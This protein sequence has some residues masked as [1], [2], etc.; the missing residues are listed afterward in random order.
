MGRHCVAK[1]LMT[2]SYNKISDFGIVGTSRGRK[3]I[4]EE[5]AYEHKYRPAP[6]AEACDCTRPVA[7][8]KDSEARS[9]SHLIVEIGSNVK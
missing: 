4:E 9:K 2:D 6:A 8:E 1:L 5:W 7:C 3:W